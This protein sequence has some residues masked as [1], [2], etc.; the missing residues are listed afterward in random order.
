MPRYMAIDF[1]L[2]RIGLAV[3]DDVLRLASPLTTVAASGRWEEDVAAIIDE[4]NDYAV[5]EFVVGLPLN[6][7]DTEGPQ[8][9]LTRRFGDAIGKHSGNPVHY[10]DERLS[11]LTADD[12]LRPAEL[13]NKKHKSKRDRVAAQVILQ[14]FL[15]ALG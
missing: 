10:F 1:G 7:D 5:D 4:A 15:D 14:D 8:A 2:K 9:K 3:G 11:S 13:T 6:M 12:L